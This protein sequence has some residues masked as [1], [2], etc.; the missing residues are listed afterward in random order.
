MRPRCMWFAFIVALRHQL[1]TNCYAHL[2]FL[3]LQHRAGPQD[4]L[5]SFRKLSYS[6]SSSIRHDTSPSSSCLKLVEPIQMGC[7]P[8]LIF[9]TYPQSSMSWEFP[10]RSPTCSEVGAKRGENIW[11][12][13]WHECSAT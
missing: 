5:S 4:S 6:S 8:R 2:L 12:R 10:P 7:V 9:Q 1:K 13:R 11:T 3:A